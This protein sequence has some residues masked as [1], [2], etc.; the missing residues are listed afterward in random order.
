M[1]TNSAIL[2]LALLVTLTGVLGDAGY[3]SSSYGY[4]DPNPCINC[5]PGPPGPAGPNGQNGLNGLAG[6]PGPSGPAGPAGP[7][8]VGIP[9]A[10]GPAGPAGPV[11]PAGP[12]ATITAT[13]GNLT[14]L[15]GGRF[16]YASGPIVVADLAAAV[17]GVYV[18]FGV[19]APATGA[20]NTVAVLPEVAQFGVPLPYQGVIHNLEVNVDLS[21]L[22]LPPVSPTT[23]TF[24]VLLSPAAAPNTGT[25][26]TPAVA[27]ASTALA[28][29]VTF[30]AGP[31][32]SYS[33]T[34]LVVGPVFVP[35]AS[36]I[37]LLVTTSLPVL[38]AGL[39]L[40]GFG[41]SLSYTPL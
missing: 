41:A 9:G 34:A 19:F 12:P 32:G 18:G 35:A 28:A 27:F 16:P 30:P 15:T 38:S 11:G 4:K 20:P 3:G 39:G 14:A 22:I 6:V 31:T 17:F 25:G 1:T 5:P 26:V 40:V 37:T 24:T 8:G 7:P 29:T 33:G 21:Y 13:G 36:K 23:F 10:A 2:A